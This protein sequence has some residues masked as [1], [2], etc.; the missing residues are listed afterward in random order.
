MDHTNMQE[1]NV[2]YK[3]SLTVWGETYSA[4]MRDEA[5]AVHHY[6]G[7]PQSVEDGQPFMLPVPDA[8]LLR[9]LLNA[10]TERG[11]LPAPAG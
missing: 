1:T 9:D 10:A 6:D 5:F 2:H 7:A 3:Q 11:F 4:Q 8:V